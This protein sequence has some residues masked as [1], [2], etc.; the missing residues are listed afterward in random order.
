MTSRYTQFDRSRLKLKP[1][2]QRE[3]K[4]GME[5]MINP[6]KE[7]GS[8][9]EEDMEKVEGAADKIIRAR[10]RKA[11]VIMAYGAHVF[12][13]GC[14]PIVIRMMKM[15]C[16]QHLSTNGAGTI[17]D[18]EMAYMLRTEEDV[19][20]YL[21]EGQFGLWDETG[22]L[23]NG[24]IKRG[25]EKKKGLGES[26]GQFIAGNN[27]PGKRY[28]LLG[29]AYELGIPLT[30][31]IGVGYDVIHEHPAADG[32][33]L[34][35]TSYRDFLIFAHSVEKMNG[36]VFLSIGSAIMA[37]MT[38]EKAL[39]MARNVAK[40][41]GEKI[42]FPIIVNDIQAGEWDWNRGEPPKNNPAYY[43]R[44]CKT[45]SRATK[46]LSY[47]DMDNRAFLHNLYKAIERKGEGKGKK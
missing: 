16:I 9:S 20:K 17:H 41:S 22:K 15:G 34:G 43:S 18:F 40:Q 13:N 7:P 6:D 19:K 42:E 23:M 12:K 5:I 27:F 47:I 45:Y 2:G 24:A 1:V 46:D 3:S 10:K 38:L 39:S 4:S 32:A 29:N 31:H 28:S 14:S 25:A 35:A 8:L 37:P 44:F 11:P 26:L 21:A 36:G 30:S 33:A